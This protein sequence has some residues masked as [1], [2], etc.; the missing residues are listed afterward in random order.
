M[1]GCFLGCAPT[2]GSGFA[3]MVC[4]SKVWAWEI[5]KILGWGRIYLSCSR[6]TVQENGSGAAKWV[7]A[8]PFDYTMASISCA[9]VRDLKIRWFSPYSRPAPGFF[10]ILSLWIRKSW[11]AY[12]S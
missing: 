10:H 7:L 6:S 5:D 8:M 11:Y 3:W 2:Q 12:Q 4:R 9:T 1:R